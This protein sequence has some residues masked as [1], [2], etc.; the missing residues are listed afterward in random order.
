MFR[1]VTHG[2][3]V[4]TVFNVGRLLIGVVPIGP[5]EYCAR[6]FA[7]FTDQNSDRCK[8]ACDRTLLLISIQV[9]C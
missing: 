7:H 5:S 3:L 1:A 2:T 9:G 8:S 6:P 4:L